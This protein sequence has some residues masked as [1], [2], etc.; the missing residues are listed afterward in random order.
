M[1]KVSEL[2]AI[3]TLTQDDLL[4]VVNDP[5]GAPSTSKITAG[6]FFGNIIVPATFVNDAYFNSSVIAASFTLLNKATPLSSTDTTPLGNIWFDDNYM[7]IAVA[8][9]S[10]KRVALSEF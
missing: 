7:Y 4:M 1:P 5:N 2:T 3:T 8:D 9:N 6:N 10:I